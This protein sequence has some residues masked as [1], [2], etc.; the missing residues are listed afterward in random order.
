[1]KN[2]DLEILDW[3]C[4]DYNE[5]FQR[6]LALVEERINGSAP[7]RLI[8]V[9]HPPVVT[10]GRSGS[11]KD[12][13]ISETALHQ[14]GVEC[15]AVDRGGQATFHGPGQLVAYPIIKLAEK[16]LHLY[17]QTL[18]EVV[19]AV[20]RT[21]GLK[22]VLKQDRP[23]VWVDFG[24]IASVGIAVRKW[25]TYHGVALNVNTDLDGFNWIVPCGHR[26]ET[27]ISLNAL[28][29]QS[30]ILAEVKKIFIKKFR[31]SFGYTA[32]PRSFQRA[33]TRPDWLIRTT[34]NAAAIHQMEGLLNHLQLA[35]VCQSAQCPNL[36]EC[37]NRGT[38]TFM[39][40]GTRCTRNCRF[41][42]VDSGKPQDVDP[43]EPER[44]A[45]AAESLKLNYVV[46]TSVARDDLD[47][48]GA[49]QFSRT[50]DHVRKRCRQARVEVLIPDFRGSIRALQK[51]CNAHPDVLNHNV[52]TVAR[53]YP[54]VR[55]EAHYRRSLGIL[56]YAAQQRVSVKSGLML[57]L[58]ETRNEIEET[59]IDLKRAGCRYFTLGQY[60]APS[61]HHL[62]VARFVP[63]EEFSQ[64]AAIA[65]QMGFAEVAA[66][67]LVRSSYQAD[68]M[69]A[70][71]NG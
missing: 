3:G 26:G 67:P 6:Q 55:P 62:P 25:V 10:L 56:E 8:L 7:D 5:A 44:I 64:W 61:Q 43:D 18:L 42:A 45:R 41:C 30:V 2:V 48:G 13:C 46:I 49:E 39:I 50:I 65:G 33:H 66:G 36:G 22:P 54:M 34:P 20:L 58:G 53:L 40:L 52:E 37:F 15:C 14:R 32:T 23:G 12:L 60:L 63:P 29:G 71:S 31:K 57:G 38:A 35:T 11:Q 51:V 1:V 17:L 19:A 24:K 9:E 68:K 70:E 27:I 16:D 59:L 21:Y 28:L 47:D 69:F 4:L